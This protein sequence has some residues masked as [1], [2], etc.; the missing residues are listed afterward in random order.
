M[1]AI[2]A[3]GYHLKLQLQPGTDEFKLRAVIQ[4]HITAMAPLE[5]SKAR[6]WRAMSIVDKDIDLPST[7]R[8]R[9]SQA[10]SVQSEVFYDAESEVDTISQQQKDIKLKADIEAMIDK[11]HHIPKPI[12][13]KSIPKPSVTT[14]ITDLGDIDIE[15]IEILL[16]KTSSEQF[17]EL[18]ELLENKNVLKLLGIVKWR[19]S[20]YQI[21][22]AFQE[23]KPKHP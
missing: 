11:L 10:T 14:T 4:H 21:E 16:P 15:E 22:R 1:I 23:L 17:A 7:T 12:T 13:S 2:L 19:L 5:P 8:K 18:F 9:D 20:L 3:T 6:I